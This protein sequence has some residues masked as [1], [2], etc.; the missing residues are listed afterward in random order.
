MLRGPALALGVIGCAL[1]GGLV[2]AAEP[3]QLSGVIAVTSENDLFGGT[4]G[5]YTNGLRAEYLSEPEAAR[6]SVRS[7][8]GFIPGLSAERTRMRRGVGVSHVIFTPADITRADPDPADRPYAAW[9]ALS[10]TLIA[11]DDDTQD[12]LQVNLG[13][14]GPLAGGEFV[15]TNW[16]DLINLQDP[17]GWDAQLRN[18]VGIEII[19]ERQ[20]VVYRTR[21][22]P[23]G[24]EADAALNIGGAVGNVRTSADLGGVLRLGRTLDAREFGPPR[25]RPA[26]AGAGGFQRRDG[27]GGYLFAGVQGRAVARDIF[28]DGNSFRDSRRVDDRRS[29]VADL[30]AGAAVHWES[31]QLSFTLVHRTEQFIAQDGPQRFGAI[32]LALAF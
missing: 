2:A 15:Q 6:G 20:Q 5:N 11:H 13:V 9:L 29:F 17:R 7:M 32:S 12:S 19:A 8:A 23:F 14:I 27:I 10:A 30:Q 22:L 24:L 31:V 16:H 18:E 25:I 26:L 21:A 28:L 3:D 4:D 1:E